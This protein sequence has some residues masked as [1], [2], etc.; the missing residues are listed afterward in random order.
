[1]RVGGTLRPLGV[2]ALLLAL[3]ACVQSPTEPSLSKAWVFSQP[4][5][6]GA[7]SVTGLGTDGVAVMAHAR[8]GKLFLYRC[9]SPAC[10]TG[11]NQVIDTG[12]V[13]DA[14]PSLVLLPGN[15]PAVLYKKTGFYPFSHAELHL[16]RCGDAA[17]SRGVRTRISDTLHVVT[18][19]LRVGANGHPAM[20]IGTLR[21]ESL[22]SRLFVA[23]CQDTA[24]SNRTTHEILQTD[25][26]MSG[27]V[28]G[29]PA[30]DKPLLVYYTWP[31]FDLIVTKCSDPA[32]AAYETQAK[33]DMDEAG[34]HAA[35]AFGADGLPVI[36]YY[37]KGLKVLKCG[38][39]ACA[40][41][42]SITT[43]AAS[44]FA[45]SFSALAIA[46]DGK[47]VISYLHIE[48]APSVPDKLDLRVV[49]CGNARCSS[50]NRIAVV[51]TASTISRSTTTLFFSATG[52]PVIGYAKG[53]VRAQAACSGGCFK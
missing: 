2:T 1:M 6:A 25:Y 42:N 4:D 49:Q 35:I 13:L 21:S 15:V 8:N 11:T 45:G 5:V 3:A 14:A 26:V 23:R 41:G 17:C 18:Q 47:P 34:A 36:A 16:Y 32:C 20:S 31:T 30:D 52:D 27:A 7:A 9:S 12:G 51:D 10:E 40:S 29:I 24:C 39:A 43:V 46:P 28:M 38:D 37:S 53:S 50:G 22:T 44:D 48:S 19:S 33:L